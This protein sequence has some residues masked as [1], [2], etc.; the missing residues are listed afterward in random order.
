MK[1]EIIRRQQLGLAISG[2]FS[3]NRRR[4]E[5]PANPHFIITSGIILAAVIFVAA[6][7]TA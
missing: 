7:F 1:N 4:T 3:R 5:I 6:I 2:P